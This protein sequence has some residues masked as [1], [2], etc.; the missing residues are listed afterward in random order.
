MTIWV[1]LLLCTSFVGKEAAEI[2]DVATAA[3]KGAAHEAEGFNEIVHKV[4]FKE[5]KTTKTNTP[6]ATPS[7]PAS[8]VLPPTTV[9]STSSKTHSSTQVPPS[10]TP[11]PPDTIAAPT[12]ST[13][14]MLST[15][16]GRSTTA[17]VPTSTQVPSSSM[18][19]P[20]S[21]SPLP[22]C[23]PSGLTPL[24][25]FSNFTFTPANATG[26]FGPTLAALQDDV[27]YKMQA[28]TQDTRFLNMAVQGRLRYGLRRNA[29]YTTSLWQLNPNL[30]PGSPGGFGI[31][32]DSANTANQNGGGGGGAS[33]GNTTSS[34]L[35][36]G[37]KNSV[38]CG[39]GGSSS[40]AAGI[41]ATF[42]LDTCLSNGNGF[43]SISLL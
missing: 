16:P 14:L 21:T 3:L 36:G 6:T 8:T 28:W 24:Y 4:I 7:T 12:I 13:L 22:L 1:L 38:Q 27:S 35:G 40:A 17:P 41:D 15:T 9:S 19:M 39:G 5:H 26:Q 10:S 34:Y 32:G 11:L 31:G 30:P 20:S 23:Q 18:Q 29:A 43:V 37:A 2:D 42:I 25:R 33:V